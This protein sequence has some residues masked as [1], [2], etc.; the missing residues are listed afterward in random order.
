MGS[1]RRYRRTLDIGLMEWRVLA[2]LAVE[3]QASPGRIGEVAG[4]DKSVVSRAV[5]ALERRGLVSVAV[6][7]A[8]GRQTQLSL[9]PAGQ[10]MHDRG[11]VGALAAE[12]GMLEG[13]SEAER[14]Q[15]VDFLKR[16]TA[17]VTRLSSSPD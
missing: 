12:V 10:A 15:L 17:N 6:S 3:T 9:T 7:Q 13:F 1:S 11:I 2:L 4:V 14:S 5:T 16:L 8:G